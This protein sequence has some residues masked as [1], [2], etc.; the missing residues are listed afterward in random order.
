M[1]SKCK[2]T[3]F[4]GVCCNPE[5]ALYR[6]ECAGFRGMDVNECPFAVIDCSSCHDGCNE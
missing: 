5:A 1:C 3:D 4:D 6:E 2:M